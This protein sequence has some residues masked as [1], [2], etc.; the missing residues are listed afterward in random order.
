MLRRYDDG[1]SCESSTAMVSSNPQTY[2]DF[3]ADGVRLAGPEYKLVVRKTGSGASQFLTR[4]LKPHYKK[5]VAAGLVAAYLS[6]PE[7]FHDEAGN[8]TAWAA[9]QLTRLGIEVTS[10]APRGIWRAIVAKFTEDPLFSTIGTGL[11]TDLSG[12]SRSL[13]HGSLDAMSGHWLQPLFSI[14]QPEP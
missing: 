3:V 5:L 7:K 6:A 10:A 11:H 12:P 4:Y 2:G 9:E 1:Q 13:C 8:L 14:P